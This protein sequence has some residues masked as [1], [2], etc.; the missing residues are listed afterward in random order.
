[1]GDVWRQRVAAALGSESVLVASG[2]GDD[3]RGGLYAFDGTSLSVIDTVPTTGVSY[4]RGR[5][6]RLL[7]APGEVTSVAE[8]VV[9]DARGVIEYRRLDEVVDPHDVCGDDRGWLIVSTGT[10]EIVRVGGEHIEPVWKAQGDEPDSC[11]VNCVSYAGGDLYATVFGWFSSFKGWR[12]DR[13]RGR[14]ILLNLSTGAEIRGLSHPHTPRRV[15]GAWLICESLLH[16]VRRRD[17]SGAVTA[18]RRLEGYTRGLEVAGDVV[19]VGVSAKRTDTATDAHVAVLDRASLDVLGRLEIPCAELYDLVVVPRAIVRGAEIGFVTNAY[20]V[21]NH[22][23]ALFGGIGSLPPERLSAGTVLDPARCACHV[24]CV[25]PSVAAGGASWT[26]DVE[27]RNLGT[28]WLGTVPPHPVALASRWVLEGG[29]QIDGD[30][31]PLP[32]VLAPAEHTRTRLPVVAPERPGEYRLVVS[33]VH[34]GH[35]WF[36]DIDPRFAASSTVRIR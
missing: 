3:G 35:F 16:A 1:M 10:N 11:H 26:V 34:E 17:D 20:R 8:L 19:F 13:A 15:D 21:A 9:S 24:D 4:H 14:G 30:R 28:A 32:V 2:F 7:R 18:E 25:L 22:H 27:V 31:V 23:A 29:V 12:D 33:L 6:A 36:D 5:L